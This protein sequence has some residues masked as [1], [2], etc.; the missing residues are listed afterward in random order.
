[1]RRPW[2]PDGGDGLQTEG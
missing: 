1:M 2:V